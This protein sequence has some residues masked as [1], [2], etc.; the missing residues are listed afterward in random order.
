[1]NCYL[2]VTDRN[3]PF[4]LRPST[5][6][7]EAATHDHRNVRS[8]GRSFES[9]KILIDHN[10]AVIAPQRSVF[11]HFCCKSWLVRGNFS[12]KN[13]SLSSLQCCISGEQERLQG[14][15]SS[16]ACHIGSRLKCFDCRP[17]SVFW[18]SQV[19]S[20]LRDQ[21]EVRRGAY[22]IRKRLESH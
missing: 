7:L 14:T 19:S 22:R 21:S 17:T 11:T 3:M 12:L 16:K 15:C 18:V 13:G 5:R 9:G 2:T 10:S 1:M 4:I 20:H 8:P 6:Q